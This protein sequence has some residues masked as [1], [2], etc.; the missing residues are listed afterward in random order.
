V[1]CG[2]QG[3]EDCV[4]AYPPGRGGPEYFE[5]DDCKDEVSGDVDRY[6]IATVSEEEDCAKR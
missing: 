4:A 3:G 5:E 2:G 6:A 1:V